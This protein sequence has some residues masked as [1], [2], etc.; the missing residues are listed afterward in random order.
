MSATKRLTYTDLCL[1]I[2]F[3]HLTQPSGLRKEHTDEEGYP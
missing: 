3:P 2:R 1:P